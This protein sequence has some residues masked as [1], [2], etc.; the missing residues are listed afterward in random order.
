MPTMPAVC[1][2]ILSRVLVLASR[3]TARWHGYGFC[4]CSHVHRKV[5]VGGSSHTSF[6]DMKVLVDEIARDG[7]QLDAFTVVHAD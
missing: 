3:V 2:F 4:M 1:L 5:T 7:R 6:V